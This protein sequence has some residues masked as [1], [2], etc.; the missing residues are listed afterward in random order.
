MKTR[1]LLTMYCVI[2]NQKCCVHIC[3]QLVLK[4]ES[5]FIKREG[6]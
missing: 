4:G 5:H 2:D 3:G 6:K 1:P